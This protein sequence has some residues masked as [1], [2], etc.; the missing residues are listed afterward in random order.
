MF[1][2]LNFICMYL[3]LQGF[4][5]LETNFRMYAYS[6]SKLHCEILRLFS[7]Y[8][9]QS[10]CM[11]LWSFFFTM[12]LFVCLLAC[13]CCKS[14]QLSNVSFVY[15]LTFCSKLDQVHLKVKL[16]LLCTNLPLM[17]NFIVKEVYFYCFR[18]SRR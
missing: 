2:Y 10:L 5:V 16:M 11:L 18:L 4:V 3:S 9:N 13:K 17:L 15:Q 14:C 8:A 12:L 1:D 6:T 7:R